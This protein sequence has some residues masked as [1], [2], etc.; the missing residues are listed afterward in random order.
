MS[1]YAGAMLVEKIMPIILAMVPQSVR[2]VGPDDTEEL[3][4]DTVAA[5]ARMLHSAEENGKPVHLSSGAKDDGTRCRFL[6]C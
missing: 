4:Q 2:P 1:P 3:V 5:A 6:A